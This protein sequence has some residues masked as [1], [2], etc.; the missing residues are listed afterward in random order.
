[1][2]GLLEFLLDAV[3]AIAARATHLSSKM[4]WPLNWPFAP[5]VITHCQRQCGRQCR[6]CQLKTRSFWLT[7]YTSTWILRVPWVL[8]YTI[9]EY[10]SNKNEYTSTVLASGAAG[11]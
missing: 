1:M 8:S 7:E 5:A 6:Q 11:C 2:G 4:S 10:S 3:L 9:I